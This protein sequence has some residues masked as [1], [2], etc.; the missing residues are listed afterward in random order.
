MVAAMSAVDGGSGSAED[1]YSR[2][3]PSRLRAGRAA[4]SAQRAR[5]R[6]EWMLN[7]RTLSALAL[8]WGMR[9]ARDSAWLRD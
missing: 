7:P 2:G 9:P 6:A 3:P 5:A 1:I 8:G 4:C